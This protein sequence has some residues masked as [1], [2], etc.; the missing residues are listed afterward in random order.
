[1]SD[2]LDTL[3]K[4]H[5]KVFRRFTYKLDEKQ[6]GMD[7][8]WVMPDADYDGSSRIVGDC[9]DFALACRK[10]VRDAGLDSRLVFCYTEEGEGHAVLE[11]EG[12]ILDN[13]YEQVVSNDWL[14]DEGYEFV[15][16]SG[17]ESGEPWYMIDKD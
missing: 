7:E 8:Y 12:W 17:Y 6:Y 9:E 5:R 10:L 2:L 14:T 16:V 13:R 1:M 11:V 3:D 4:I 15:A